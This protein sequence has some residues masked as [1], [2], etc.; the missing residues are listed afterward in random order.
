M[1]TFKQYINEKFSS[2]DN[3]DAWWRIV[4]TSFRL[5]RPVNKHDLNIVLH[6]CNW[7]FSVAV[8]AL[9]YNTTIPS[10]IIAVVSKNSYL[11]K[12][13]IDQINHY[14]ADKKVEILQRN[15]ELLEYFL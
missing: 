2:I 3:A 7:S 5:K 6:S 10:G 4:N 12:S 15:A 14:Y 11:L 13:L 9:A 1:K 8:N